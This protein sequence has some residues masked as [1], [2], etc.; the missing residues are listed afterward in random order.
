MSEV[1]VDLYAILG[2]TENATDKEI[3][4]AYFKLAKKYHPDKASIDKKNEALEMY[5]LI[6]HAYNVLSDVKLKSQYDLAFKLSK[7]AKKSHLKLQSGFDEFIKTQDT[8][9][10]LND[11]D[12]KRLLDEAKLKFDMEND[13]LNMKHKFN[14][15][16]IDA[17]PQDEYNKR[18]ADLMAE[19]KQHDIEDE[20]E[21]I[22]DPNAK[23]NPSTFN[24][25]WKK[26]YGNK[27]LDLVKSNGPLAFNMG[28]DMKSEFTSIDE[29]NGLYDEMN[30]DELG[31]SVEGYATV[32]FGSAH[33]SR[34]VDFNDLDEE[35]DDYEGHKTK[36]SKEEMKEKIKERERE[37]RKLKDLDFDDFDNNN[38][39][40][41]GISNN[42][43]F[44]ASLL[45]WD[46]VGTSDIQDKYNKL[47]EYRKESEKKK[48]KKK[49]KEKD[50]KK[51]SGILDELE[52]LDL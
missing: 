33:E 32:N 31:N 38:M 49:D 26:K 18:L 12:R 10:N 27:P 45:D 28:D 24:A 39:G 20:T 16:D 36:L 43:G 35:D 30:P 17:I 4:K 50:K 3:Q 42:L 29:R 2:I 25:M 5:E 37:T 6:T 8:L 47:L 9:K 14:E 19:R 34:N 15:E 7:D 46:D 48:E 41:F 11:D 52:K 1:N 13:A 40:Y 44:D 21:P 23:F 22:F 51:K